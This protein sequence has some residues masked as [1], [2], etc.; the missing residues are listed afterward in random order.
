MT[1]SFCA[2]ES[3]DVHRYFNAKQY[4]QNGFDTTFHMLPPSLASPPNA[5]RLRFEVAD[6]DG[7]HQVQLYTPEVS[8]V[9][10]SSGGLLACKRLTRHKQHR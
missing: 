2:A 7:L 4:S 8:G 9:G 3:L 6:F 10:A 5:I 1:T